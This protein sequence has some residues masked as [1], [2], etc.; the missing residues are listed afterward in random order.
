MMI[1]GSTGIHQQTMVSPST[2]KDATRKGRTTD[3]V[4]KRRIQFM[5]PTELKFESKIVVTY[6]DINVNEID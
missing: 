4:R 5:W 3:P 2:R 6:F 1:G